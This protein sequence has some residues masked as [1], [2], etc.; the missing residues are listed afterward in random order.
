MILRRI[1]GSRFSEVVPE[2]IGKTVVLLASGPSLTREQA[3]A[4]GITHAA[5]EVRCIAVND[6]YL[7]AP[8]AD[9]HYAADSSWHSWH[10][11][12]IA[13]PMLG[14]TAEQVRAAWAGFAGQKCTIQSSGANVT[15]EAV[16]MMR[17]RDHPMHGLGLSMEPQYL[18][19]GRNSGFQ[20]LNLAV[21]AGA[22]TIILLGYDGQEVAG[23]HHFHGEHPR[24]T[25]PRIYEQCRRAM[26]AAEH[27]LSK[28]G[29][30]VLNCTLG[31]AI[32]SFPRTSLE[33]ALPH[34]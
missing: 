29:V 31:S 22:K 1:E 4:V 9:V 19:T 25:D 30:E 7:V 23:K 3:E 5:G 16:H 26:S 8:W 10:T 18:V 27:A 15:D 2:W 20:A 34:G 13:K 12:G 24:P 28:A 17:N 33:E 11:A 14:L 32:N 6:T 21:L